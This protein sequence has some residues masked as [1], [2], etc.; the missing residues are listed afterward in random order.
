[1]VL[2]AAAALGSY[3]RGALI[4]IVGMSIYLWLKSPRKL[5]FGVGMALAGFFVLTFMSQRWEMRM[6]TITEY[7]ADAS[8]TGRINA[9]WMAW[10]LAKDNFFGGGFDIY[11]KE[12]FAQYAPNPLD[13]HAAHSI[14]FQ[15]LGEHGYI[16]LLLFLLL[17]WF[18]WR[19][20]GW[21]IREGAGNEET[22]W[23]KHLGAMCQVSL[24]GYAVGGAFL[25][26]AYFDLPYDVL[27]MIVMTKRWLLQYQAKAKAEPAP[28]GAQALNVIRPLGDAR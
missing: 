12:A 28:E 10:N 19:S 21:L 22:L 2:T 5:V 7:E 9:W 26:L 14:Y 11:T 8:A 20:A 16:G 23:C 27:A 25:S 24:V 6:G 18:V 15:M 3:S 17:W 13:V 1:M 4:A